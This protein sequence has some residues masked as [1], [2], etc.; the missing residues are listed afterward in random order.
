MTGIGQLCA[1]YDGFIV[2]LWGVVH[3]GFALSLIHI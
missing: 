3:D 1:D 2:D